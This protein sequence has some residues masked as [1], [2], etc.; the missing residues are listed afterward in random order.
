[1]KMSSQNIGLIG[2]ENNVCGELL[3]YFGD[4]SCQKVAAIICWLRGTRVWSAR[5]SAGSAQKTHGHRTM[6][7]TG[8]IVGAA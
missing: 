7:C 2:K 6:F 3:H 8:V 4:N 5:F 1:M